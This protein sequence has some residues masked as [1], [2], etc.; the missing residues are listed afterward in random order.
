[1]ETKINR[2]YVVTDTVHAGDAQFVLGVNMNAPNKFV[3]W[4][5]HGEN[6]YNWGHYH[7]DLLKAQ[8][9][10]CKRA[11]QEIRHLESIRKPQSKDHER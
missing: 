5:C 9:D 6:D 11:L 8:K 2:G 4:Q 1:M 7:D 10:L 3:T